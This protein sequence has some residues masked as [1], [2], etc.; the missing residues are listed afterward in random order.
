MSK[1]FAIQSPTTVTQVDLENILSLSNQIVRLQE[2]RARLT[3]SALERL[4]AGETAEPGPRTSEVQTLW[5]RG[6][7]KQKLVVR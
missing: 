5:V 4:L 1:L 7:R 3:T 2:M 6:T